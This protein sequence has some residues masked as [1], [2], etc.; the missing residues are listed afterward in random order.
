MIENAN[1]QLLIQA[2]CPA[3]RPFV[4]RL[5]V[6]ESSATHGDAHLP[7]T[8]PVAAFRFQGDCRLDSGVQAPQAA[9]TGLWDTMRTH[10][11]SQDHAVVIVTFTAIG[12]AALLHHPFYEFAN[13]TTDLAAVLGHSA[14]LDSLYEQ[15]ATAGNH[16]TR[17]RLVEAFLLRYV[18]KSRLDLDIAGAV[19]LIEQTQAMLRIEELAQKIGLSQSALERRFQRCVGV[20]PRKFASLVRLKNV[21][22]LRE[23]GVDLTTI[24]HTAGYYDQAHFIRDF[25]RF[26][27][28]APSAFFALSPAN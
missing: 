3:L 25:K 2:P 19:T 23:Q 5:M 8:S 26:T 13:S 22:Q 4:R 27:G 6:V 21:V 17:I 11:H 15:L 28:L 20:A 12:A 24:A 1:T 16:A 18:D 14:G 7:D 10:A 9:L